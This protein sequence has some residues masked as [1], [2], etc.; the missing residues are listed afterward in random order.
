MTTKAEHRDYMRTWRPLH[1]EYYNHW[2][3]NHPYRGKSWTPAEAKAHKIGETVPLAASCEFCGSS[4]NLQRHHPELLEFPDIVITCCPSC[5]KYADN[6][7][8]KEV[9]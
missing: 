6:K 3:K 9:N 1:R 4:D 7:R 5:H 2:N 8:E